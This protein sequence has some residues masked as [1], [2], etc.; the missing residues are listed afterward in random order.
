MKSDTLKKIAKNISRVMEQQFDKPI[1]PKELSEQSGV[2]YP[3]LNRLLRGDSDF[4]ILKFIALIEALR[5]TPD[6]I[7]EG[8]Y[9]KIAGRSK[10]SQTPKYLVSFVTS[11]GLTRCSVYDIE[12][13]ESKTELSSF[14]LDCTR[15]AAATIEMM[16]N[17]IIDM[18]GKDVDF[19][20]VYVYA[21]V[22][23]YEHVDGRSK[24]NDLAAREYAIIVIE[25]DWKLA[26][27]A[28]FA[29]K[30]GIMIT[31]NDGYVI[32]YSADNGKHVSK[33]QGYVPMAAE[34]GNMW[35]GCE[36]IKHAINVKEGVEKRTLLSDRIL[37]TVFSD[38]NLLATRVFDDPR[39]TY[40]KV[41]SIVKELASREKKS[42][43]LIKQ[44]FDNIWKRIN[45][46]DKE[47]GKELP[48]CLSGD[49]AYLYEE[50]IPKAR[51]YKT[52]SASETECFNYTNRLLTD[53][54]KT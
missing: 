29:D 48:I 5:A 17:A 45:L 27:S 42:A 6:D 43:D 9:K 1:T 21:S 18:C 51:L 4:S 2:A 41:S 49:L 14:S 53:L 3:S 36:A 35:L 33:I 30:N 23:G 12:K 32:S 46:I 38:L 19:D 15:N 26:H 24:L 31:I 10:P 44:G 11:A 54:I 39:D 8:T 22:L 20:Q 50:F 52:D 37:G 34:A 47:V 13:K 7:L 25:P 28:I 40:V 16:N